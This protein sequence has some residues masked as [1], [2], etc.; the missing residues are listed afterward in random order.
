MRLTRSGAVR[1]N[2]VVEFDEG[3][4]IAWN[5]AE[6]GG[7]PPGHLWRWQLSDVDGGTRVVHTYDWTALTDPHRVV[8]ARSTTADKLAASIDRLAAL[9]ETD[10][11]R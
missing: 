6:V 8:R 1:E 10:A 9:V 3:R 5:P 7:T 4:L 2:R 11:R